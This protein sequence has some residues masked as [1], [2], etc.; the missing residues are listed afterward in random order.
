MNISRAVKIREAKY[1]PA[2][3]VTNTPSSSAIDNLLAEVSEPET[4]VYLTGVQECTAEG[5][6]DY[7]R[8][9]GDVA[10]VS[11]PNTEYAVVTFVKAEDAEKVLRQ[12]TH[13]VF[14][15][16]V[17][18][19]RT[20]IEN[21]RYSVVLNIWMLVMFCSVERREPWKDS[22]HLA[23]SMSMVPVL[24]M[25]MMLSATRRTELVP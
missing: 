12:T 13:Y 4:K 24:L 14:G 16:M 3:D 22:N 1:A 21:I 25:V 17:S 19:S 2:A 10:D 9:F 6:K 8:H 7:F 5:I 15:K 23:I 11:K 20:A 18:A